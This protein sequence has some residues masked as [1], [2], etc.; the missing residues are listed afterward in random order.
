MQRRQLLKSLGLVLL[1][2]VAGIPRI[3]AQESHRIVINAMRFSY[4]PGTIT[5]KKGEPVILVLQQSDV[6]HGLR[7]RE[8]GIDVKASKGK[9]GEAKFTPD[10]VGEFVGRCSVFCGAKHGSMAL[11][12]RVV[13]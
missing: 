12:L 5:L 7:V 10:K 6:P 1:G 11:T 3:A 2:A 9:P 8:L 4:D 13:D